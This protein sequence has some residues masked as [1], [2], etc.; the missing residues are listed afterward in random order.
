MINPIYKFNRL[1]QNTIKKLIE[2]SKNKRVEASRVLKSNQDITD[3]FIIF[4]DKYNCRLIPKGEKLPC[5]NT[6]CP[7]FFHSKAKMLLRDSTYIHY[8]PRTLPL[9][10]G[11]IYTAVMNRIKKIVAVTAEGTYSVFMPNY[12][13]GEFTAKRDLLVANNK[14]SRIVRENG[15]EGYILDNPVIFEKYKQG[16]NEFIQSLAQKTDSKYFSNI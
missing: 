5:E 7:I 10:I 1:E 13:M 12:K 6:N 9:S 2:Y 15:G 4:E 14:L 16:L 3:K 11:D 8:H